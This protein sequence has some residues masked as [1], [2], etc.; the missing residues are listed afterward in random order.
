MSE[1]LSVENALSRFQNI[2]AVIRTIKK[3]RSSIPDELTR[4]FSIISV[5]SYS[6]VLSQEHRDAQAK[7]GPGP[8][9]G[10][11]GR[12]GNKEKRSSGA[13]WFMFILKVGFHPYVKDLDQSLCKPGVVMY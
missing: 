1:S 4:S 2:S 9:T 3:Y 7:L 5:Q 11:R 10:S 8:Q 6:V 12:G 13:G